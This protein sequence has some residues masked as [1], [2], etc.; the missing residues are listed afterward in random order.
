MADQEAPIAA[1][2]VWAAIKA[3][4]SDRAPGP[5]GFTGVFY[6]IAWPVIQTEVMEAVETF[7]T[8]NIRNL[9]KLNNALVVLLPKKVGANCLG[10][11]RN[12]LGV[13]P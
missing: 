1:D 9:D 8:R 2:E 4:T 7:A 10:D 11:L 3:K 13:T 12:T 5:D 6:K